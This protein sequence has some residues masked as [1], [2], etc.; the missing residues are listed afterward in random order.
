[1]AKTK[2]KATSKWLG[3]GIA[4]EG[5][6]RNFKVLIDEPKELGGT[7]TAMNPIEL[8]LNSLASCM[9]ICAVAFSRQC[10]VKVTNCSVD[11]EGDLDPDGFL[12]LNPDVRM[13]YQE[14]RY[15]INI[16]SPSPQENIQKLIEL[17]E[18]RCPVSDTLQGVKVIS[19]A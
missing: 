16:D 12:G 8:L 1:M 5:T 18:K 4:C 3:K 10:G 19:K 6:S 15:K 11:I 13:G 9:T 2:F 17:I 14:I 7:D